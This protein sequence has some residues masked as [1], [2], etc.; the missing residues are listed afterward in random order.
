MM[1]MSFWEGVLWGM[2]FDDKKR[3]R[4]ECPFCSAPI[5]PDEEFCPS[6]KRE[7]P[8]CPKCGK[9]LLDFDECPLCGEEVW[10]QK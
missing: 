8:R 5:R 1:I 3:I 9:I 4:F 6:C 10:L 7:L 2:G